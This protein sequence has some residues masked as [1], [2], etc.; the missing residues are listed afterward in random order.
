[1][2]QDSSHEEEAEFFTKLSVAR[3]QLGTALYLFLQDQDPVS[4]HCLACGGGE[5]AHHLAGFMGKDRFS[6]HALLTFPDLKE[7]VLQG[8]RN[9]YWNAFKHWNR[10][11]GKPRDDRETLA[12]FDDSKNDHALFVGWYDFA[13]AS[14]RMP[15]ETQVFEAWYFARFPEKVS[16]EVQLEPYLRLFPNI[17]NL[18][19]SDAKAKLRSVIKWARPDKTVM[20]DPR[21]DK[22]KLVLQREVEL[23]EPSR[24]ELNS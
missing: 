8:I 11:D 14:G 15:I 20:L 4:V 12:L 5:L 18:R 6:D 17:K 7:G 22:R 16:K 2:K 23:I 1:M 21:T 3:R 19:R 24:A 10:L 9:Q 13:N